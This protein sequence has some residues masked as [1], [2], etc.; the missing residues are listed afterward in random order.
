[1]HDCWSNVET[2]EGGSAARAVSA[3]VHSKI[4][5]TTAQIRRITTGFPAR[6]VDIEVPPTTRTTTLYI[7]E[8]AK[9]PIGSRHL[10]FVSEACPVTFDVLAEFQGRFC[11][12]S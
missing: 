9:H 8:G 6:C 11:D 2:V 3:I 12:I 1:M 10:D 5:Q 4:K 7:T